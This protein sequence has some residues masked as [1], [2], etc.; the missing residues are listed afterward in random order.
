[1][2]RRD[3]RRV[4]PDSLERSDDTDSDS[5]LYQHTVI[6][7][8][9]GCCCSDDSQSGDSHSSDDT[10]L[11]SP[12]CPIGKPREVPPTAPPNTKEGISAENLSEDSGYS[13]EQVQ[14]VE[15]IQG[16][17]DYHGVVKR[18]NRA[19]RGDMRQRSSFEAYDGGE[20]DVFRGVASCFGSSCQD[21]RYSGAGTTGAQKR[22]IP[23]TVALVPKITLE[24]FSPTK[25][26]S[27]RTRRSA[28]SSATST[29]EPDL[30]LRTDEVRSP[31]VEH[32]RCLGTSRVACGQGFFGES[33][34]VSSVPDLPGIG[35]GRNGGGG[36]TVSDSD[37]SGVG[38]GCS[39][40]RIV[41]SIA[42]K[43]W[44]LCTLRSPAV[45]MAA[46]FD[47]F[48]TPADSHTS[49]RSASSSGS[50]VDGRIK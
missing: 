42:A 6:G 3:V 21:L 5:L 39:T 47:G 27:A 38:V 12:R 18:F 2:E 43:N 45:A 37:S 1:M 35:V 17:N 20:C 50:D 16:Q 11:V 9:T 44:D 40:D 41:A 31:S 25:Y 23:Q 48:A 8:S 36:G 46:V 7:P 33:V 32:R 34:C 24:C 14:N 30:L 15:S 49:V 10:L 4:S 26:S 29:S 22:I 28:S 13:G 19:A